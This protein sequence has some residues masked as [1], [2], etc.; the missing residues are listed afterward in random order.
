M[1]KYFLFGKIAV[2]IPNK[3]VQTG[4]G[5]VVVKIPPKRAVFGGTSPRKYLRATFHPDK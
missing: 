2:D 4:I 5:V 1:P 3:R